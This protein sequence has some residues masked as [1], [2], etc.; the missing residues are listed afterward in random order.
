[1]AARDRA[2]DIA[3]VRSRALW[4]DS[5]AV[6]EVG[7]VSNNW[8]HGTGPLANAPDYAIIR[9]VTLIEVFVRSRSAELIDSGS[10]YLE[11][12]QS[13]IGST[14]L[15]IDFPT[16]A[17]ISGKKISL[18]QLVAHSIPCSTFGDFVNAFTKL[19]DFDLFGKIA[20]VHDRVA[21]ELGGAAKTPII[22]DG[23][24]LRATMVKLF[25]CRHILVHELP[26]TVPYDEGDI[27]MFIEMTSQL[28]RATEGYVDWLMHGDYPLTQADMNIKAAD[29]ARAAD[30]E[31][32]VLVQRVRDKTEREDFEA[33]QAAWEAY[34]A[35]EANFQTDWETGGSIRPLLHASAFEAL[36]RERIK[37][38][39]DFLDVE[40]SLSGP[41]N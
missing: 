35:A 40:L 7:A 14:G 28:L 39:R 36:T 21:V 33:A 31:L 29:D 2:A 12:A 13:L 10:P 15:K 34:R 9:L 19:F 1:M 27:D 16:A 3:E 37:A 11:R 41:D 26:D 22:T 5:Q 6:Y 8:A 17:A 30:E 25:E 20:D 24:A 32:A 4:R 38:L 23:D 18:G